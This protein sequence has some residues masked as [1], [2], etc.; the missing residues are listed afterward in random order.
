MKP[1]AVYRGYTTTDLAAMLGMVPNKGDLPLNREGVDRV[2]RWFNVHYPATPMALLHQLA[3]STAE[4]RK[5]VSVAVCRRYKP[6]SPF[7]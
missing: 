1:R 2:I 5:W 4:D 3:P 6:D 7:K